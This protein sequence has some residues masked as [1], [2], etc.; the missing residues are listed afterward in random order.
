MS[1]KK[2]LREWI[3]RRKAE[4]QGKINAF[5]LNPTPENLKQYQKSSRELLELGQMEAQHFPVK[6]AESDLELEEPLY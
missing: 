5:P 2:K 6:K 3:H 4:E 1:E